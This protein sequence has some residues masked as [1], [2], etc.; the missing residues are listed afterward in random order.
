MEG[1]DL[2][3]ETANIKADRGNHVKLGKSTSVH[4]VEYRDHLEK[5]DVAEVKETVKITA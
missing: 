1:D 5:H 2:D 4:R 3:I